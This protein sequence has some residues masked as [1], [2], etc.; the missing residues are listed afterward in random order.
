MSSSRF[1]LTLPLLTACVGDIGEGKVAAEV[2]D[3]RGADVQRAAP[4]GTKLTIDRSQSSVRALGAKITATHP[5]VFHEWSGIATV[6]GGNLTDLDFT[7]AVASLESD[8]PKLTKHL[9]HEHFLWADRHP[10]ATFDA[11]EIVAGADADGATHTVSGNLTIRG[12]T[13]QVRFPAKIEVGD[14]GVRAEAE[15]VLDRQDFGITYKGKADDL[16]QDDV[17]L[18]VDFVART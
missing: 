1:L 16:I 2:S 17:V 6:D 11:H 14:G 3:A 18:T 9:K 4:G 5:I 12:Q 10:E 13:K 8:H 15:F 7:V